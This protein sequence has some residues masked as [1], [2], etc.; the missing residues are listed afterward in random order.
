VRD[1]GFCIAS[2][3]FV[4]LIERLGGTMCAIVVL[5][6]EDVFMDGCVVGDEAGL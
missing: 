2:M 5:W 1:R 6:L 3:A 4:F